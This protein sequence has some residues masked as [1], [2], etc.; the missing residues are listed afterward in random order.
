M[1]MLGI[2]VWAPAML[3]TEPLR[4]WDPQRKRSLHG[5]NARPR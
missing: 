5:K 1:R 4:R 3:A 2:V